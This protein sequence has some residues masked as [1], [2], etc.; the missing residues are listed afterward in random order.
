MSHVPRAV[1][2]FDGTIADYHGYRGP[3]KFEEPLPGAKE[4]LIRLQEE[5]YRIVVF[6]S[7]GWAEQDGIE[8]YL[9]SHGLPFAQVICGKPLADVYIDDRGVRAGDWQEVLRQV[10]GRRAA[11]GPH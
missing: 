8:A 1:V 6:T 5:G 4:A 7:R 2:D 11:R 3:G 10:L 9:R